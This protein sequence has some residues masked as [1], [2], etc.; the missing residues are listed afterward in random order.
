MCLI[1]TFLCL[2]FIQVSVPCEVVSDPVS[3]TPS[4]FLTHISK[5]ITL[6]L[7]YIYMNEFSWEFVNLMRADYT[8]NLMHGKIQKQLD[9]GN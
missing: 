4:C 8:Q 2:S 7:Y 5:V 3:I 6:H 1:H 9:L